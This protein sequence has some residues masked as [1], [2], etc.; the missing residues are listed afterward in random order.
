LG[1]TSSSETALTVIGGSTVSSGGTAYV[2]ALLVDADNG[3]IRGDSAE[4]IPESGSAEVT[5]LLTAWPNVYSSSPDGLVQFSVTDPVAE[6]VVFELG[7]TTANV[8]LDQTV[9]ITFQ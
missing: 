8:T 4:L 7:D 6:T 5:P 9:S 2:E 1:S 3:P